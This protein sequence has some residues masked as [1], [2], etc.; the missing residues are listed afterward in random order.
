MAQPLTDPHPHPITQSP[1]PPSPIT[2]YLPLWHGHHLTTIS[3]VQFF[4]VLILHFLKTDCWQA[5]RTLH[6][7]LTN[8]LQFVPT[9]ISSRHQMVIKKSER[10][11]EEERE[12]GSGRGRGRGREKGGGQHMGGRWCLMEWWDGVVQF[13]KAIFLVFYLF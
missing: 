12:K 1:Q 4:Q 3:I 2:S 5:F 10:K 13:K 11:K 9:L 8:S 7:R 6:V